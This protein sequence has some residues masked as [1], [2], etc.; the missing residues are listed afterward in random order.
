[1]FGIEES[2]AGA[3]E[4]QPAMHA[5][6]LHQMKK[7]SDLGSQRAIAV[8]FFPLVSCHRVII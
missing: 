6:S 1:M 3:D 7:L 5:K 8:S 2:E 4:G